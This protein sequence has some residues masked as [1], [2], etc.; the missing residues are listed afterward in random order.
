MRNIDS[1]ALLMYNLTLVSDIKNGVNLL[2]MKA[3]AVGHHN[4]NSFL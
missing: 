2:K 1:N 3:V 4:C